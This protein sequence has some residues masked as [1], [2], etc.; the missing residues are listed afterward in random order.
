MQ[1]L[2][3]LLT[4]FLAIQVDTRV[5]LKKNSAKYDL[6][7]LVTAEYLRRV[8]VICPIKSTN[9]SFV[10]LYIGFILKAAFD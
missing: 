8:S 4:R 10:A 2:I 6:T 1:E 7:V 9:I 3:W 5:Y